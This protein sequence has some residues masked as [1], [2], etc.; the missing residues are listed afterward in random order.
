MIALDHA[1]PK[2]RAFSRLA[3]AQRDIGDARRAIRL[4]GEVPAS[5]RDQLYEVLLSAAAIFYSRPF[6]ATRQY[7][8]IPRKF[9]GFDNPTFQTFHDEMISARNRFIAHCDAREIKVHILAKGTQFRGSGN[10]VYTVAKHATAVGTRRFHPK[11]IPLFEAVCSFQL[12][13]L[14]EEIARLSNQLFPKKPN[15]AMQRTA[16]RSNA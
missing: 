14:G 9:T 6:V 10:S 2:H 1:N 5:Q 13:R 16:P 3:I 8:A 4:I 12:E 15:Q 7:P 11:G